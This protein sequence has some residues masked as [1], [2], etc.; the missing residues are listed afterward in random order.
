MRVQTYRDN[1]S[2]IARTTA[3]EHDP[4]LDLVEVPKQRIARG[5][6]RLGM[7]DHLDRGAVNP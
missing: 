5:R 1:E 7:L 4:T 6:A 3:T 2:T